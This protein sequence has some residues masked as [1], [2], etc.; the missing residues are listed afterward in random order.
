M[1]IVGYYIVNIGFNLILLKPF[2][3]FKCGFKLLTK[4]VLNTFLKLK[5]GL[6]QH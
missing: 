4:V 2:K 6:P 1:C 3:G 5:S